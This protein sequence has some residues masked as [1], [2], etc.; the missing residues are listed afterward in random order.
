MGHA[1]LQNVD[2]YFE[3]S[4]DI[5]DNIDH[6]MGEQLAPLARAFR[7]RMIDAEEQATQAGRA[8]SRIID[9]RVSSNPLASCSAGG[10][11]VR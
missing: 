6:A 10:R 8:G 5:V 3:A 2:V 4:P 9:F 1:D 7:G 11:G